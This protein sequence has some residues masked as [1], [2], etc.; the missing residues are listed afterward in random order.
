MSDN[1]E[2]G[3]AYAA[4]QLARRQ[5]PL[6]RI[7]KAAYISNLL[8]HV[9]GPSVDLGCGA[10]QILERLPAGSVGVEVNPH[11]VADLGKRGLR[12]FRATP[13]GARLDLSSIA[14]GEFKTLVLS[15]VLEHFSDA[16]QVLR[17]LLADCSERGIS[18][19]IL[20]VPGAVGYRSDATH[21]TFIDAEYLRA[22]QLQS[23]EGYAIAHQSY[24]PGNIEK[25]G[26]IFVYHEMMFV[27]KKSVRQ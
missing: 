10:G 9:E 22:H 2:F 20:V 11:L 14:A 12:V 8:K 1:E 26:E 23:C 24:F 17:R 6:R 4:S 3:G 18:T 16:D 19:V 5:H 21:K 7:I 27:Y 15:H 13:D 25:I